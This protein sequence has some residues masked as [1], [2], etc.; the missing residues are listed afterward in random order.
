MGVGERLN[1][2]EE[3]MSHYPQDLKDLLADGELAAQ[4]KV[5]YWQLC[6]DESSPTYAAFYAAYAN[7]CGL[8]AIACKLAR[9]SFEELDYAVSLW[10]DGA[11]T[12]HTTLTAN[13]RLAF[14]QREAQ[15]YRSRVIKRHTAHDNAAILA[16]NYRTL[17]ADHAALNIAYG[18]DT[19]NWPTESI[20]AFTRDLEALADAQYWYPAL[21][22]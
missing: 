8:V 17:C 6:H 7:L 9:Y 12:D 18:D 2:R 20:T 14:S 15:T 1:P 5:I 11:I 16:D 3:R 4:E 13:D 21:V 10:T 19:A 22:S